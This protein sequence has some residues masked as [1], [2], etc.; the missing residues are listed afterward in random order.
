M[1]AQNQFQFLIDWMGL[2]ALLLLAG[3][4]IYRKWYQAFPFFF[5]YVIGAESVGVI[6]LLFRHAPVGVYSNVYWIS[7]TALAVFAFLAAYELFFKRLF[8]N[9]QKTRVYRYMFPATAIL[10]VVTVALIALLGGHSSALPMTSRIYEFLR[11]TILFFFV[12]LML[13]MGR[14]WDRQ[15]F[16]VAFGFGLDVSTSLALIG[17][18]THTANR[19]AILSRLAVIAYDIACIVWVYCF[20]PPQKQRMLAPLQPA[21]KDTLDQAKKWEETLKDFL[22]PGKR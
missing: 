15:E 9:F 4:L 10:I 5:V 11:A 16:G 17:I 8:P 3:L 12:A 2:P 21:A 1:Y 18:W 19:N 7:D 13:V 14:Q 6:R 20:W 22:T